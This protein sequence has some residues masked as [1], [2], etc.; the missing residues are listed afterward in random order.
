MLRTWAC[1]VCA[2]IVLLREVNFFLWV[3]VQ[4]CGHCYSGCYIIC[5]SLAEFTDNVGLK[6]SGYLKPG[7]FVKQ[8]CHQWISKTNLFC[9]PWSKGMW[10]WRRQQSMVQLRF[11]W[12]SVSGGLVLVV[13]RI[14]FMDFARYIY[15]LNYMLVFSFF[16][17]LG[18][19]Q[20]LLLS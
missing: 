17:Y 13:V 15:W 19:S 14:F 20:S 8:S 5:E 9:S 3:Y 2:W 12:M 10:L 1:S 7:K 16:F 11:G 4:Y 18:F 6:I